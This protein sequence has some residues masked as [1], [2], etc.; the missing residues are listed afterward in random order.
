MAGTKHNIIPDELKMQLTVPTY[1]PEAHRAD[2]IDQL[3]RVRHGRLH[4]PDRT[5]IVSVAK[6]QSRPRL[7]NNPELTKRLLAVWKKTLGNET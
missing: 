2:G 1:K 7:Y 5:P 4:S 6:D 3:Q